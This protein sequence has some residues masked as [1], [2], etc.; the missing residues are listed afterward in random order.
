MCARI[1]II[2]SMKEIMEYFGLE[3][4]AGE[5]LPPDLAPRYNI[6]PTDIIPAAI[7]GDTR[8]IELLSWG[9]VP[10]WAKDKRIGS[11]MINA[12]GE[13]LIDKPA[14]RGLL[15]RRRCIVPVDGFYEWIAAS[16]CAP[17]D[18]H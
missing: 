17:A 8:R 18:A 6:A 7:E 13:T 12:R 5:T 15:T 14:F 16:K 1:T 9:L 2:H 4:A 11:K 3:D 10:S